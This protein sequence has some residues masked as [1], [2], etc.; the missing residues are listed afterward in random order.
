V[1][2]SALPEQERTGHRPLE[3]EPARERALPVPVLVRQGLERASPAQESLQPVLRVRGRTDHRPPAP[4]RVRVLV[5]QVRAP[6]LASRGQVSPGPARTDHPRPAQAPGR[7][8][9]LEP[10]LVPRVWKPEAARERSR[11]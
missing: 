5:Q 8:L 6:G 7:E 1:R 10:A 2:V 4:V 3:R 11:R 9:A